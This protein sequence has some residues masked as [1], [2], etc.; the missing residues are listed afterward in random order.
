M[1]GLT[2][3]VHLRVFEKLRE[4][5]KGTQLLNHC[6]VSSDSG[7]VHSFGLGR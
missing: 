4:L 2:E 5:V 6:P 3:L 7:G 1:S